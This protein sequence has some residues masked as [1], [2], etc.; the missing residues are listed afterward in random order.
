MMRV[1]N[2]LGSVTLRN[3]KLRPQAPAIIFEGRTITHRQFAER[4]FRLANALIRLGVRRGDRVAVLA[5]NCPEYMEAYAAGELGG[6][7][8]V[9]INYRLAPPEIAYIL[10][11]SGPKVLINEAQFGDSFD[12]STA[13]TLEHLVTFQGTG[14]DLAYESL[15][16]DAPAT[17]PETA[18]QPDD[19]AFLI[20]TSGTTGRPKGV[21]LTHRGQMRS[22]LISAL[23]ALVRP[24]DRVAITMPLYHIGAK[25][26][27]LSHS[28]CGCPIIL[29]KAFRPEPFVASLRDHAATVTLLAPTMI[30][31][32]LDLGCNGNS[33]P[34][35]Q[36]LFYS[37]APMSEQ[38]LRR[39]MAAFG[40][41]FA[42][43]YGMTES[44][45]PGCTLHAHQHILEGPP[46]VVRRLR[47]AGQ[48]MTGCEVRVLRPD[49]SVCATGE[50]GEI[51]I[52]SEA[53][54]AG[55][56]NNHAATVETLRD[57]WVH[58]GDL[59][60]ADSEDFIFVI[61]R[62]KDMIVS[63]GENIY[64]REVENALMSHPA[65]ADAAV[66]GAPDDRWGEI[67]A[68]FVVKRAGHDITADE[69]IAHC[70]EMIASYKR[71]RTVKFIDALPKLPNGKVE[72]FKLRAPLWA[73]RDRVV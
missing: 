57:G 40:S 2:T 60:A 43:I 20:Y 44:G 22:A 7:T 29:H 64:S 41:I 68:A 71:P 70:R 36:K 8:T 30:S 69:A 58:S 66:V 1:Q 51:V 65:I 3:L 24:T 35:L 46:E 63:G 6:W 9:T 26:T 31:D 19:V 48:P 67:V 15:L 11:D 49:G 32:L 38:L 5:Q 55:Y 16:A 62:V 73:G 14:P 10:G 27:W 42:Q 4:V 18:V 50:P 12:A 45:G 21:M 34:N 53:V 52:R 28:V 59:G 33:L 17:P 39:G 23:D 72:K 13:N 37:A 56:W 54:M 47:S 61:D 25:N